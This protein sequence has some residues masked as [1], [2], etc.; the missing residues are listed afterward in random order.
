ML[1]FSIH[2][3]QRKH[4]YCNFFL[5]RLYRSLGRGFGVFL[6]FLVVQSIKS[7]RIDT[8]TKPRPP[9]SFR[10]SVENEE[11]LRAIAKQKKTTIAQVIRNSLFGSENDKKSAA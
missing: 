7:L 2:H 3:I 9:I 5:V 11:K 4:F 6:Y 8:M 1:L 10:L